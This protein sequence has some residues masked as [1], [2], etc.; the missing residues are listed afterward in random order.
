MGKELK[1]KSI[2]L[3]LGMIFMI[4]N[5]GLVDLE[6]LLITIYDT[7]IQELMKE[8]INCY[9]IGAYRA[10]IILTW[11]TVLYDSYK[12]AKYLAEN[13]D[14]KEAKK[15]V[16]DVEEKLKNGSIASE[17]SLI[18][19]YIYKKFEMIDNLELQKLSF[20][21]ELRNMSA[22]MSMYKIKEKYFVPTAEDA[23]MV[24]RNAIEIILSQPS[25]LNK[26]ATEYVFKEILGPYFPTLYEKFEKIV[27]KE[28]LEKGGRYF[29]RNLVI[30]TIKSY[31]FGND[32]HENLKNLFLV[33]FKHKRKYFEN[34]TIK[35]SLDGITS[36]SEIE[37]LL[38][39]VMEEPEILGYISKGKEILIKYLEEQLKSFK[40]LS[41]NKKEFFPF[42][43]VILK[44]QVGKEDFKLRREFIEKFIIYMNLNKL[45]KYKI[46][47]IYFAEEL[48][49]ILL[50]ISIKQLI[51]LS[52]FDGAYTFI[53]NTL[54]PLL[55]L[56]KDR[57]QL[58]VLFKNVKEN[59]GRGRINQILESSHVLEN[60]EIILGNISK[61]VLE[62]NKEIVKT[63]IDNVCSKITE[64][65]FFEG[66]KK[67][68]KNYFF[69]EVL[70]WNFENNK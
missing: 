33:L 9:N 57:K 41:D 63:F 29:L 54:S 30:E 42:L 19:N 40:N 21:K 12:K 16:L 70:N 31:L 62:E 2:F 52:W 60:V 27:M 50:D 22:H 59:R 65:G 5:K 43:F 37:R 32:M 47:K 14:D 23:R 53:K 46:Y 44:F 55:Y 20:I 6:E 38:W 25:I 7:E 67:E 18:E 11:D 17:W 15:L 36:E 49:K 61:E 1:T 34:E 4:Q 66:D 10:A 56:V 39:I 68:C 8:A 58:E 26:K 69:T 24:I 3:Y 13:F 64:I 45:Q 51:S 35:K 28:Y 48:K